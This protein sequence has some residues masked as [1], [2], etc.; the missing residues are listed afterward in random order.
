MAFVIG[1][2]FGTELV[3]LWGLEHCRDLK[4]HI[5]INGIVIITAEFNATDEQ[6]KEFETVLKKYRL[7]EIKEGEKA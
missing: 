7:E 1:Q 3:K 5:P 2:E 6:M 4:I